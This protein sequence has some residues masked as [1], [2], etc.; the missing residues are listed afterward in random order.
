MCITN[1]PLRL[2]IDEIFYFS[3]FLISQIAFGK[4]LYVDYPKFWY[5]VCLFAVLSSIKTIWLLEY[6][7]I[8]NI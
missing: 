8:C 5:N 3:D 7:F 2:Y 6:L 1:I 4:I